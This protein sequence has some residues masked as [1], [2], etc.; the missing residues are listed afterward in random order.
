MDYRRILREER[1]L[2]RRKNNASRCDDS[3]EVQSI[4]IKST[5]PDIELKHSPG[6]TG[7]NSRT[8]N[9][10]FNP[11]NL[12]SCRIGTAKS[13]FYVPNAIEN[14]TELHL[15]ESVAISGLQHKNSWIQL[16]NRRLQSWGKSITG[17]VRD[18]EALPKWL[19]EIASALVDTNI[20]NDADL[21]DHVLINEYGPADGILHHTD[22]PLYRDVVAILSLGSPCLM[23]FKNK[24][25]SHDIGCG[26]A[27]DVFSVVLQPRSLLVFTD[28]I[29]THFMH[30]IDSG[31]SHI[32]GASAP[33]LNM[34]QA[35]VSED[36]EVD[37]L[38]FPLLSFFSN[39]HNFLLSFILL[40]LLGG[41]ELL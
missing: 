41:K 5:N 39:L 4:R 12:E 26:D 24:L 10:R 7:S 1:E 2:S 28:S 8:L 19:K 40:R 23:T 15:L 18:D 11:F 31:M 29:Y 27:G 21:P 16:K 14:V 20:F 38:H 36:D 22:G 13:L 25:E 3:E 6:S 35:V 17:E 32:V 33:C 37:S 34:V 30:G 9:F